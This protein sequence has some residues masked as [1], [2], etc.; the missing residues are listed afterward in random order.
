MQINILNYIS[1][2][3]TISYETLIPCKAISASIKISLNLDTLKTFEREFRNAERETLST[4]FVYISQIFNR[5]HSNQVPYIFS[6]T[7]IYTSSSR[8]VLYSK[9]SRITSLLHF[10]LSLFF[11][12]SSSPSFLF[13]CL[14][15]I[16]GF[17]FPFT[18][19]ESYY[20]FT[21]LAAP[22]PEHHFFPSSFSLFST[23]RSSDIFPFIE[24]FSVKSR[25]RP[26]S[27][28]LIYPIHPRLP[29]EHALPRSLSLSVTSSIFPRILSF[30]VPKEYLY[31]AGL[32]FSPPTSLLLSILLLYSLSK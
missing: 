15:R 2:S 24:F 17:L 22:F 12:P 11:L 5:F 30:S 1:T 31:E 8:I 21:P 16:H 6:Y 26:P 29:K 9:T 7:S 10:I 25:F 20:P 28:T 23:E 14:V 27:T 19:R 4:R 13:V 32:S 18:L 3:I